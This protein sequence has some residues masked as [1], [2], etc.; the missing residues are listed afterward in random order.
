[1]IP[2]KNG[3]SA[4]IFCPQNIRY[5]RWISGKY[6]VNIRHV[7]KISA[8]Y[9]LNIRHIRF[10]SGT[11]GKYPVDIRR[12]SA[13]SG[14]YPLK[15]QPS[16]I[17]TAVHLPPWIHE[18]QVRPAISGS[19]KAATS[20]KAIIYAEKPDPDLTPF[21]PILPRKPV[22]LSNTQRHRLT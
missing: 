15:H 8:A 19:R 13:I 14:K 17:I 5:I 20:Q 2:R 21:W 9:P 11:S 16:F 22:N 4:D 7:R 3:Y 18:I 12:I 6:P 1:M 10:I